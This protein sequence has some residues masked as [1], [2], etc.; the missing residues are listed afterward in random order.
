MLAFWSTLRSA[1]WFIPGVMAL[2]AIALAFGSIKLDEFVRGAVEAKLGWVYAG[3]S[4]GAR[5]VLATIAGS[6]ITVAGTTF[7]ITIAAFS[8]ASSQFGPRVLRTFRRDTGNQL[9]LGTF[10]ATFLYCLLVL[11]TVRGTDS[12]TYVPHLSV[13]LG[14]VLACL[15]LAVLIFFI[16]HTAASIQVS[17][18][19]DS[20]G[21]ELDATLLRNCPE[22]VHRTHDE[23]SEI[24]ALD[25][26]PEGQTVR[27]RQQG[28]LLQIDYHGLTKIAIRKN[29]VFHVL[30]QPGDYLVAGMP[31]IVFEPGLLEEA[32]CDDLYSGIYVGSDRSPEQDIEFGFLQ[33]AEIGVRALSPGINDPFTAVNCLDRTSAAFCLFAE[34]EIPSTDYRDEDG[35]IRVIA[36]TITYDRLVEAAFHHIHDAA[37]QNAWVL[38]HLAERIEFVLSRIEHGEVRRPLEKEGSLALAEAVRLVETLHRQSSNATGML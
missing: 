31:I 36:R 24:P 38:R 17:S 13:T 32:D 33:L 22:R 9:V 30:I 26:L 18:L 19:I 2:G 20:V 15:S 25:N 14:V 28:Y 1:Y 11:R 5:A 35:N 21:K 4:A 16:H 12:D 27:A 10:I 37:A 29:G 6:I 23:R 8:L 3:G 34:R 7:S